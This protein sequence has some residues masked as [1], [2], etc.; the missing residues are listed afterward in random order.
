MESDYRSS[1]G[2][3]WHS[4]SDCHPSNGHVPQTWHPSSYGSPPNH[5]KAPQLFTD[6]SGGCTNKSANTRSNEE[7]VVNPK[8]FAPLKTNWK[9]LPTGYQDYNTP[10]T[11]PVNTLVIPLQC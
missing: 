6:S 10:Q 7:Y 8:H 5:M 11:P 2:Q 9:P 3:T 1:N 4:S